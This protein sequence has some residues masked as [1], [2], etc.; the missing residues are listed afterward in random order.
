MVPI[1]REFRLFLQRKPINN[2]FKIYAVNKDDEKR[3]LDLSIELYEGYDLGKSYQNE[4]I[5]DGWNGMVLILYMN[6]L[7]LSLIYSSCH[8]LYYIPPVIGRGLVHLHCYYS[9]RELT[10]GFCCEVGY[11][12]LDISP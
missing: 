10:N 9:M 3:P 1:C 7:W 12:L 2:K 8:Y 4:I 5:K 6:T 11:G